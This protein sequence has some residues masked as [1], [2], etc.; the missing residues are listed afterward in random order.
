MNRKNRLAISAAALGTSLTMLTSG[1]KALP[2]ETFHPNYK[3]TQY[4]G[5]WAT[6]AA[7]L[8]A[9][10]TNWE[11]QS[12]GYGSG[13]KEIYPAVVSAPGNT[14]QLDV[15]IKSG[16]GGFLVWLDDG[17]EDT[18]IWTMGY[19]NVPGAGIY[20]TNEY[21]LQVPDTGWTGNPSGANPEL[22]FTQITGYNLELD[23]GAPTQT[24]DVLYNGVD[25][26]N[27]ATWAPTTGGSWSSTASWNDML[28]PTNAGDSA[29]FGNNN[30]GPTTITLDGSDTVSALNFNSPNS[31][32]IAPG[33]GGTLSLVN[34]YGIVAGIEDFAGN[35]T[36][37]APINLLSGAQVAVSSATDTLT[38]SGAI[39]GVGGLNIASSPVQGKTGIIQRGTVILGAANSY[40]GGTTLNGGTLIAAAAGALPTGQPVT[41]TAGELQLAK[42]SGGQSVSA[43]TI[44]PGATFDINNDHILINYTGANPDAG[45]L[46][47]LKASKLAGWTGTGIVSSAAATNGSYGIAY[48]NGSD[49]GVSWLSSGT[50]KMSYALNGDINQDGVVNGTDFGVL[51]G[52]FGKSVTGGWEQGDLNYDGTVNG[53]DFG[54]LAGNFGKSATGA[55]VVLPASQWAALDSFAA[56]HGLLADVPEPTSASLALLA[57]SGLAA[58][59]R[60]RA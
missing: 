21:V 39:S 56:A 28:L 50:I 3:M 51:A 34:N 17:E 47:L 30:T 49:P 46:A 59:R 11:V 26:V 25:N 53:T 54:L 16:V 36:V 37:S 33:T 58:R 48:G 12:T 31:Y 45:Y 24:Y 20:G 32:N 52:N 10:P 27:L 23:P 1:V 6:A 57:A 60:R 5:S 14:L 43:L 38:L 8:T 40:V 22:D 4:Y 29:T 15:T 42:N 44:A 2:I 19:G 35:H 13:Y 18:F 55:S 9:N 41:I 7:T